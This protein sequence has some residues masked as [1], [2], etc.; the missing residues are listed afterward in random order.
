MEKS[1]LKDSVRQIRNTFKRFLSIVAIVLLGV[2]FFAGITATSPDM[3]DTIDTYFDDEDVMDIEVISTLGLTDEDIE[4]LKQVDGTKEVVGTYSI[5][6]TF[7]NDKKEYV[8]KIES[9]PDTIN[10]VIL[11][12]GSLP[13][14]ADECVV[15]SSLLTMTGYKIGDYITLNPQKIESSTSLGDIDISNDEDSNDNNSS[16]DSTMIIIV[17]MIQL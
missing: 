12:E 2:G 1:L 11:K 3:K 13:Q 15:E 9:M 16:N 5:D 6:A 7:S 17:A 10:N 4:A 14:N 8:V